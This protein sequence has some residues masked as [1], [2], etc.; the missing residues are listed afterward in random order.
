V[1]LLCLDLSQWTDVHVVEDERVTDLLHQI[2]SAGGDRPTP[3]AAGLTA[4]RRAGAGRLVMGSVVRAGAVTTLIAKVFDVRTMKVIRTVQAS[5][6]VP[7]SLMPAYG[8]LAQS[9]LS[10]SITTGWSSMC[11]AIRRGFAFGPAGPTRFDIF[12][13]RSR[14]IRRT[15][16]RSA[17]FLI[18]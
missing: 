9:I 5:A 3:L 14:S 16:S 6:S 1:N 8:R 17:T 12:S 13:E 2:T 4:A 7:D 15:I 18:S 10:V 11:Q